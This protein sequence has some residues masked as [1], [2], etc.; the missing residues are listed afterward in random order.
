[1]C[2][3]EIN[4]YLGIVTV[5]LTNMRAI[6]FISNMMFFI[7]NFILDNANAA[8][9]LINILKN[10]TATVTTTLLKMYL[11]IGMPFSVVVL[12]RFL[13]FSN[14]GFCGKNVG[15]NAK[16]SSKGLNECEKINIIG[17]IMKIASG[18]NIM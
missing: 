17:K 14:V 4:K 3:F 7:L 10:M 1:M 18:I 8:I 13:K 12:N 11:E 15:G 5:V 2:S 16:S 9:V 6:V